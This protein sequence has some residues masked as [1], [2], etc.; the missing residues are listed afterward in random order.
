MVGQHGHRRVGSHG[1]DRFNAVAGHRRH[2]DSQIFKRVAERN[3][4]LHDSLMR[5]RRHIGRGRQISDLDQVVMEPLP[6]RLLMGHRFFQFVVGDNPSLCCVNQEHA[7]RLQAAF[8]DNALR[9][10]VQ[11]SHFRGHDD[12]IV[13]RDIVARRAQAVPVQHGPDLR[14]VGERNGR[15]TVPGFHQTA[16]VL[17]ERFLVRAHAFV[18][19]PGFR[20]HHHHGMR[21]R[22]PAEGEKFQAVVKH[23]GV[24]AFAVDDRQDFRQVFSEQRRRELLLPRPHPV[25]VAA[26][27]IDLPVMRDHAVRVGPLPA[28][29]RVRTEPRMDQCQRTFH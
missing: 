5:R 20:D 25:D 11:N 9:R 2:Q 8:L 23:R 29:E 27:G 4:P 13:F 16:M 19:G 22:A 15:R 14:A 1:A 7:A 28:W 3:L 12:Q 24:A 10:D 26:N 17:V 21:Q 18:A 6:V